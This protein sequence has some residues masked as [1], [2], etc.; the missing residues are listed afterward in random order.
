MFILGFIALDETREPPRM[1]AVIATGDGTLTV[2]NG[3]ALGEAVTWPVEDDISATGGAK[4]AAKRL[5]AEHKTAS[6]LGLTM[7][8]EVGMAEVADGTPPA[9][10]YRA[11]V[12]AAQEGLLS[13]A[14]TARST[15]VS[16]QT[17]AKGGG[18]SAAAID[19]SQ[20]ERVDE[21]VALTLDAGE[22]VVRPNGE[23]Y[24]PRDLGGHT[25]IAVIRTTRTM[26]I[27]PLLSGK[28][29]TGKTALSDAACPD[30]ITLGCHGDMTTA[31][32]LGT[33]LPTPTGGWDWRDGPLTTAMR[34]GR[35]LLLDEINTMPTEVSAVLHSALDGRRTIRLDDRPDSD[36]VHAT[37]GF[38]VIA[39]YNPDSLGNSGLSEAITSRFTLPI[40]VTTDYTAA[41]TIGVPPSLVQAAENLT[42][43]AR[44]S[45]TDGG[46]DIWAP[47]MRELLSA[48]HLVD[49][50]L[51][52][53]FAASALLSQCPHP[54]DLPTVTDA[55]QQATGHTLTPLTLGTQQ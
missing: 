13:R 24:Y 7:Y 48:K 31:H 20:A 5:M 23:R 30:L 34:E 42:T 27:Y 25:D 1:R 12:K 4:A 49:A 47:Q 19:G 50:G 46:P 37:D 39:T 44:Q 41:R 33:W 35:V 45:I 6:D 51:G 15:A 38:H 36:P 8:E 53:P 26:G 17:V 55:L 2:V 14:G 10:L 40:T 54:E 22:V 21:R 43:R 3:D 16:F 52:I 28:A 11:F 9:T 32:L 18:T 29:G